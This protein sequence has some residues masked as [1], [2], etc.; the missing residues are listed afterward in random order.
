MSRKIALLCAAL[1]VVLTLAAQALAK[2]LSPVE[3]GTRLVKLPEHLDLLPGQLKNQPIQ[4]ATR[5]GAYRAM[6]DNLRPLIGIGRRLKFCR[7]RLAGQWRTHA[8]PGRRK[9]CGCDNR[10]MGV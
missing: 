7:Q 6:L 8:R 5:I 4:S 10:N 3:G 1:A 2:N 9:R